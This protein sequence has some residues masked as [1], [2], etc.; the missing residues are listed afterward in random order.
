MD[1]GPGGI[2]CLV[3]NN[4]EMTVMG[5]PTNSAAFLCNI[6]YSCLKL[7]PKTK[8]GTKLIINGGIE[9]IFGFVWR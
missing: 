3:E 6:K 2:S 9:A 1:A 8:F 7:K 5:H 4:L